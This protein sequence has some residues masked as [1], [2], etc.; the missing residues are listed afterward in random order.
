MAKGLL[1]TIARHT[2]GHRAT[3]PRRLR[4]LQRLEAEGERKPRLPRQGGARTC[5]QR[6]TVTWQLQ[7]TERRVQVDQA[8]LGLRRPAVQD[9]A[10]RKPKLTSKTAHG[11]K[12]Q[13]IWRGS[14]RGVHSAGRQ[15]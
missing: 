9:G 10:R 5:S 4:L 6:R 15:Y 3:G 7:Q 11:R 13:A 2:V 8:H 12:A 1:A 14:A